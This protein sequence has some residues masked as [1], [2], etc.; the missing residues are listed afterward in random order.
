MSL[1]RKVSIGPDYKDAMHYQL[2][3]RVGRNKEFE[4]VQIKIENDK[5]IS[6]LIQ[7]DK[8][9]TYEWKSFRATMPIS[10]EYDLEF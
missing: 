5:D 7:N 4:I 9:E 10:I 8:K 6:I 2:E 3:Q 1:I